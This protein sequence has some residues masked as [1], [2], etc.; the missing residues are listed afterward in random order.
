VTETPQHARP[1][2]AAANGSGSRSPEQIESDIA[3]TRTQLAGTIDEIADKVSPANVKRRAVDRVKAEIDRIKARVGEQ[4][5]DDHGN[6][7]V[8]KVAPLAAAAA[9]LVLLSALRKVRR[10][11]TSRA[12]RRRALR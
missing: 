7:D 5:T 9:G 1:V 8:K 11:R 10:R 3:E 12:R 2:R 4:L 6:I